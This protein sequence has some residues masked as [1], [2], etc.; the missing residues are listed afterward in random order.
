MSQKVKTLFLAL[1]AVLT[2]CIAGAQKTYVVCVGLGNYDDGQNPLPCSKGDARSMAEF[3]HRYNGSEVFMLLD[4][5][6]TRDHI[7]RVLKAQFAKSTPED[8]VIFAYSGHGFDGGITCYDTK[9]AIFCYEV[10]QILRSCEARRKI[11]FIMSCQSGSFTKKYDTMRQEQDYRSKKSDVMLYLSSRAD[12]SSWET[13]A[14]QR[15]FF[16]E[17]LIKGLQGYADKNGDNL[18]TARELFNYVNARVTYVTEGRQHPQMF[19]NFDDDMVI[20]RVRK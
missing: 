2:C 14:M 9:N 11:M 10:Q 15:S 19:G 20:V 16:F 7:L 12:E 6:A 3:F 18:V 4:R 17:F 8:E 13:D 5:N 1:A